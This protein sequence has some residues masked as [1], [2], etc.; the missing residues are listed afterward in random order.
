MYEG[1]VIGVDCGGHWGLAVL[2]R[3]PGQGNGVVLHVARFNEWES[4]EMAVELGN[5][6]RK[7]TPVA[8]AYER[9]FVSRNPDLAR[10][11]LSQAAKAEAVRLSAVRLGIEAV[12]VP[13]QSDRRAR[14]VQ[15]MLRDALA[16]IGKA[17]DVA[18]PRGKHMRDAL[19]IADAAIG[20]LRERVLREKAE[21]VA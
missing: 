12:L 20:L 9:A 16:K 19:A 10:A 3:L 15:R 4:E 2:Q 1:C 11:A 8:I 14:V 18:A 17:E 21:V 7:W 6:A 13:P 5:A